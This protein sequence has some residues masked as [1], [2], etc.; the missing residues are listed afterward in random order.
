M[1]D[2]PDRMEALV[3]TGPE[4]FEIRKVDV[5]EPGRGEVLARVENAGLPAKSTPDGLLLADP[6]QNGV[7]L[8]RNALK[9]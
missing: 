4:A 1:A 8:T 6:S 9:K 5:P 2:I 7:M 3:L